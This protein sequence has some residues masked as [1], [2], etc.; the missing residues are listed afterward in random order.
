MP[1]VFRYNG[2]RFFFFSNE[3]SPREPIH[4]HAQ[5][6]D[7]EAKFWLRP[8]VTVAE[9]FGFDRP[10]LTELLGVVLQNRE[11]IEGRW[12]EYFG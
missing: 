10:A 6:G 1:V 5:Q 12:H 4:I 3:G 8:E 7:A 9:N 2:V 11:L